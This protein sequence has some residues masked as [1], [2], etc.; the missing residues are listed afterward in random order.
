MTSNERR[1]GFP[2]KDVPFT[3]SRPTDPDLPCHPTRPRV[4][5]GTGRV[6][7]TTR[8]RGGGRVCGRDLSLFLYCPSSCVDGP[9][10]GLFLVLRRLDTDPRAGE[11]YGTDRAYVRVVGVRVPG[12][13]YVC[14]DETRLLRKGTT[15]S[16][17]RVSVGSGDLESPLNLPTKVRQDLHTPPRD[18]G[19][20]RDRG[21]S[22]RV[23]SE[24]PSP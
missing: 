8:E 6:P 11:V 10:C 9:V 20:R 5:V 4:E 1:K 18:S 23:E 22:R 13:V 2:E 19:W 7:S 24:T 16:L 15:T 14:T 3:D 12:V 21:C 17:E